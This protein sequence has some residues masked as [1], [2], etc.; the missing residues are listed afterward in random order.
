MKLP[1]AQGT[2][3]NGWNI[4]YCFDNLPLLV[5]ILT[6]YIS[7]YGAKR[8]EWVIGQTLLITRPCS[9]KT[10]TI[11]CCVRLEKY[12][13]AVFYLWIQAPLKLHH[14]RYKYRYI[15]FDLLWIDKICLDKC[16]KPMVRHLIFKTRP[17]ACGKLCDIL[18]NHPNHCDLPPN[19]SFLVIKRKVLD[20]IR[21]SLYYWT[22]NRIRFC[23]HDVDWVFLGQKLTAIQK[24]HALVQKL[25]KWNSRAPFC[26]HGLTSVPE[27]ICYYML[28]KVWDQITYPFL[29]SKRCKR[30]I[31]GTVKYFNPTLYWAC[32]YLS[33]LGLNLNN[34]NE[35]CHIY[36]DCLL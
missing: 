33:M 29:N 24:L 16:I 27:W 18:L 17:I 19:V 8:P 7:S 15:E 3:P 22:P 13:H 14:I 11:V 34:A 32:S 9:G 5:S 31:W 20:N 30:W 23:W 6:R 28:G 2:R 1:S 25:A 35:I 36:A 21:Q 4:Q 12:S 10:L 26:L